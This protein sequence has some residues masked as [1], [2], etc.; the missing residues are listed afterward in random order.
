MHFNSG[1]RLT[2]L[3]SKFLASGLKIIRK[4]ERKKKITKPGIRERKMK[5]NST[6]EKTENDKSFFQIGL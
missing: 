4:K 2:K 3:K 1:I 5:K 6:K